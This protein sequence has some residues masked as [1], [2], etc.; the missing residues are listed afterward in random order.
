MQGHRAGIDAGEEVRPEEGRQAEGQDHQGDEAADEPD[1]M[2]QGD[3]QHAAIAF[4]HL[5]EAFLEPMLEAP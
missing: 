3:G 5:G 1:A 2:L 4:A